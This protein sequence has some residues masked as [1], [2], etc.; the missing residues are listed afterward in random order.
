MR[1]G[2]HKGV[3]DCSLG[4]GERFGL[5]DIESLTGESSAQR[6]E[7]ERPVARDN[8]NIVERVPFGNAYSRAARGK[9]AAQLK[10]REDLIQRLAAK[11]AARQPFEKLRDLSFFLFRGCSLQ[12]GFRA[13]GVNTAFLEVAAQAAM[14]RDVEL[15]E[16]VLAPVGH[17]L[18]IDGAD[19]GE[20]H[21][22]KRF[23]PL[24]AAD[25]I[26]ELLDRGGF[27]DIAACHRGR[28]L[29]VMADKEQH[30]LPAGFIQLDPLHRFGGHLDAVFGMGSFRHALAGIVE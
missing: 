19:I 6:G 8:D 24:L 17:G 13:P 10:V 14:R 1:V 11:V 18:G 4:V 20:R 3:E 22:R 9:F 30:V 25:N 28:H 15:P 21:E 27:A 2:N 16:K 5:F 29:Q 12:Q 26:A 7:Q 23:E